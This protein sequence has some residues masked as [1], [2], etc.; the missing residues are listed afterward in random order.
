[1]PHPV[2]NTIKAFYER[3]NNEELMTILLSQQ[4]HYELQTLKEITG[5]LRSRGYSEKKLADIENKYQRQGKAIFD[6]ELFNKIKDNTIT[7]LAL[8]YALGY[9]GWSI[10]AAHQQLGTISGFELQY[11]LAGIPPTLVVFL[12]YIFTR[13]RRPFLYK[14]DTNFKKKK[15]TNLVNYLTF[16][17]LILS[18]CAL[19]YIAAFL[20]LAAVQIIFEHYRIPFL[21]QTSLF[22][23]AIDYTRQPLIWSFILLILF[24]QFGLFAI[25]PIKDN[26]EQ[27]LNELILKLR[28]KETPPL[29][30]GE[31]LKEVRAER[32][33]D[34]LRT[35]SQY[36]FSVMVFVLVLVIFNTRILP[37]IP[38]EIGGA[39][40]I[41][42]ILFSDKN[43]FYHAKNPATKADTPHYTRFDT[44]T[45][46]FEGT[47]TILYKHHGQVSPYNSTPSEEISRNSIQKIKFLR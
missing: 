26:L 17:V 47:S 25:H 37:L 30:I 7:L 13:K 14:L 5:I 6:S 28:K 4:A 3:M 22:L 42:A 35:F 2:P 32:N 36:T 19:L 38:Q 41:K 8:D 21:L 39:K 34:S 23:W 18:F 15:R 31:H 44:V 46:Y 12:I 45:I 40:P 1:M 16:C 10:Y 9:I 43:I 27:K 20:L 29:Q 33:A 11:I 24:I